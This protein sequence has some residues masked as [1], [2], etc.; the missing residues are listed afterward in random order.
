MDKNWSANKQ[1]PNRLKVAV[2]EKLQ[3]QSARGRYL[4]EL[5]G[6]DKVDMM[7]VVPDEVRSS[8]GQKMA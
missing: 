5:M 4:L 2:T 7:V 3:R 1:A 8:I 6:D